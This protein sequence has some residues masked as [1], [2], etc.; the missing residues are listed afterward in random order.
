MNVNITR[1][2]AQVAASYLDDR[3]SALEAAATLAGR[4]SLPMRGE[5]L[6]EAVIL[7]RVTDELDRGS[8]GL[9]KMQAGAARARKAKKAGKPHSSGRAQEAA[10]WLHEHPGE[11]TVAQV[12]EGIGGSRSAA[13]KALMG[14]RI[15]GLIPEP[16]DRRDG[17]GTPVKVY[18]GARPTDGE[19]RIEALVANMKGA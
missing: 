6:A 12:T 8:T 15:H 1:E 18:S 5:A 13:Q 11:W 10:D 7:R 9:A 3:A 2:E 16:R 19:N 17:P 4:H 14:A